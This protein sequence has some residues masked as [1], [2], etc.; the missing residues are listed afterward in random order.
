MSFNL[1]DLIFYF[2]ILKVKVLLLKSTILMSWN[3][4]FLCSSCIY[5]I[6][7]SSDIDFIYL[8][9]LVL[10]RLGIWELQL[11]VRIVNSLQS[12]AFGFVIG[13]NFSSSFS[14]ESQIFFPPIPFKSI[15]LVVMVFY[16]YVHFLCSFVPLLIIYYVC[17]RRCSGE[18]LNI[19]WKNRSSHM[20]TKFNY[21]ICKTRCGK[22][23][24]HGDVEG[25][26]YSNKG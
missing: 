4:R 17:T 11:L 12:S 5:F 3:T 2:L 26:F 16:L 7:H 8:I 24:F 9:F 10:N 22:F 13:M 23:G 15:V 21:I 14:Q 1:L 20:Y 25:C 18:H 19:M 6:P